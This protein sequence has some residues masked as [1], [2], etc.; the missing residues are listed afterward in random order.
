MLYSCPLPDVF[1]TEHK[2]SIKIML[3]E[4]ICEEKKKKEEK[5]I[6]KQPVQ[7][8]RPKDVLEQEESSLV[9]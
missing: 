4:L 5:E 2:N 3:R 7:M 6:F 8:N 1:F 9:I